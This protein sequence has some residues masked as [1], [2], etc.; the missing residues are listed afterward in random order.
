[1]NHGAKVLNAG[2]TGYKKSLTEETVRDF[3]RD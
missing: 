1:M 3:N 2:F